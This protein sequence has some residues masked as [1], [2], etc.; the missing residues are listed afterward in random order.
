MILETLTFAEAFN[1]EDLDASDNSA[2]LGIL[3]THS[4][5]ILKDSTGEEVGV[6]Y[7]L[8]NVDSQR[9]ETDIDDAGLI[10]WL[11]PGLESFIKGGGTHLRVTYEVVL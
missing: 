3:K 5:F 7:L 10:G 2:L 9:L 11:P 4:S 1:S 8:D 6:L